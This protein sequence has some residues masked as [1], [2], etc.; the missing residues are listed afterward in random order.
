MTKIRKVV[1]TVEEV[2]N[3]REIKLGFSLI[4]GWE[5]IDKTDEIVAV[6]DR[7][8]KYCPNKGLLLVDNSNINAPCLNRGK[9]HLNGQ[10]TSILA[11]NF[12]KSVVN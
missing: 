9:L 3:K 11:D 4:V 12:R 1:A 5:N 7:L 6:N 8:Q 2:D 10:G